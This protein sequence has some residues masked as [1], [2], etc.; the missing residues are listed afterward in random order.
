MLSKI[1]AIAIA[2]VCYLAFTVHDS[3]LIYMSCLTCCAALLI[4][5]VKDKFLFIF[6]LFISSYIIFLYPHYIKGLSLGGYQFTDSVYHDKTLYLFSLF[7]ASMLFFYKYIPTEPINER[8]NIK[9]NAFVFYLNLII[10]I[11][12]IL[13]ASGG[14]SIFEASY[15]SN[16]TQITTINNYFAVFYLVSYFSSGRIKSR[17]LLLNT[18]C[19]LYCLHTLTLGGRGATISMGMVYYLLVMDRR[20]TFMQL[21]GCIVLVFMFMI[22]WGFLRAGR[23]ATFFSFSEN[24]FS[25]A[26][27]LSA[28]LSDKY[29]MQGGHYTD[30]FHASVRIISLTDLGIIN[31]GDRLYAFAL[32]IASIFVPYSLLPPISNLASYLRGDYTSLGGGMAF[33]YFYTFL[34]YFG[35]VLLACIANII[36]NKLRTSSNKYTLIYCILVFAMVNGWFAYNPITMFKLCLWGA[37]YAYFM[38]IL[39]A[40]LIK[41]K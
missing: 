23:A 40:N 8:L 37:M 39:T 11:A 21:L 12:I 3:R 6:Y 14:Q 1:V 19:I 35:V 7:L 16:D 27:G 24:G 25:S 34:S 38:D 5:S 22:F 13:F 41:R 30:I 33:A 2:I 17:V 4:R 9:D 20:I 36:W 10:Q 32:F 18:V 26:L 29:E 31:L 28:S 15:G